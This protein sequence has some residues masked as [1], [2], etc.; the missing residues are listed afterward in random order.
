MLVSWSE[1]RRLSPRHYRSI[2]AKDIFEIPRLATQ[3]VLAWTLPESV[4]GPLSQLFG[5]F[6]VA[7]YP[8]RTRR[9]TS[10]IANTFAGT[11]V[12]SHALEVAAENWINR[13]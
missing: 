2:T 10:Q 11:P 12:A 7:M 13:Y 5:R 9:E 3:G 4:W 6:D 8:E 1:L